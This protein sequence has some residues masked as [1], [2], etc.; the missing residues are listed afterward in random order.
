MQIS[1]T[2]NKTQISK[3][4]LSVFVFIITFI[5]LIL[6]SRTQ[7]LAQTFSLTPAT[8]SKSANLEFNVLLN[9]DTNGKKVRRPM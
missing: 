9:I 4:F 7:A 6:C 3:L 5:L 1:K 8:A 2:K